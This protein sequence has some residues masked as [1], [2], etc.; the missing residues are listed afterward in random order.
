MCGLAQHFRAARRNIPQSVE[1]QF[2]C[3][4]HQDWIIPGRGTDNI[5]LIYVYLLLFLP[6]YQ[7]TSLPALLNPFNRYHTYLPLTPT[8]L[9]ETPRGRCH[10]PPKIVRTKTQVSHQL[11]RS[12][13]R[14]PRP[15]PTVIRRRHSYQTEHGSTTRSPLWATTSRLRMKGN[16]RQRILTVL[17]VYSLPLPL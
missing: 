9:Q 4:R 12:T 14:S 10:K 8:Y 5:H 15:D 7:P 13:K 6:L 1:R 2:C 11:S 17:Y 3:N 16:A